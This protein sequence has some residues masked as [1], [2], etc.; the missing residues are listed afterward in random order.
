MRSRTALFPDTK[1]KRRLSEA[2]TSVGDD[3]FYQ[4]VLAMKDDWM[5]GLIWLVREQLSTTNT[6]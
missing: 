1:L 2:V 3:K 5:N 4:W 6:Y